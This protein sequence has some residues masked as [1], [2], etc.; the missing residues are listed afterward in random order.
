VLRLRFATATQSARR[1]P[2]RVTAAVDWPHL[3]A[4]TVERRRRGVG[5]GGGPVAAAAA[6]AVEAAAENVSEH[7]PEVD[8]QQRVDDEVTREADRLQHVG[9]LDGEQQ[10]LVAQL[11]PASVR[12]HI[13][14]II[15]TNN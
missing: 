9:E 8:V 4:T 11:I 15:I 6:A 14:I 7:V 10:R 13:I 1:S 12:E 2:H 5:G 3:E